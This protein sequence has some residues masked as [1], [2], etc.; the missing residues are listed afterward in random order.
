MMDDVVDGVAKGGGSQEN[1]GG[2]RNELGGS[3]ESYEWDWG[4][5]LIFFQMEK[6]RGGH[7]LMRIGV[8]IGPNPDRIGQDQ[9]QPR[10]E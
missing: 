4:L 8:S 1:K 5:S 7:G 6:R 2:E 3:V 9:F 10:T